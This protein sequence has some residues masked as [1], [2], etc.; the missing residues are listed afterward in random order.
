[1]KSY[2]LV[3]ALVC[4]FFSSIAVSQVTFQA[5]GGLGATF[6]DADLAGSTIEYYEGRSYG[7][8]P[9]L[10]VHAK[11]RAGL[12]TIHIVGELGVSW[13]SN[14]GNSEPTQGNVEISQ[15]ILQFK[16]GPEY[17]FT[18]PA[19]PAKPYLGMNLAV[20]SFSGEATFRGVSRVPT[21]T[22]VVKSASRFGIGFTA[23]ALFKVSPLMTLDVSLAYNLLNLGGRAWE[24]IEPSQDRRVDS[25]LAL[26]DARDTFFTPSSNDHVIAS[27]RTINSFQ[28]LITLMFGL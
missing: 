9:G 27:D 22:F 3:G 21:A 20:N 11:A 7:L 4:W 14:E 28:L 25:Y 24:D 23:G 10:N 26:N 12:G 17:Q 13:L 8:A 2:K 19:V 5:G 15:S 1:M 18:I 6:P 16:I